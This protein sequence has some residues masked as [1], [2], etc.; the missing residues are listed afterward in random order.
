[1]HRGA[2]AGIRRWR[3]PT[4]WVKVVHLVWVRRAVAASSRRR[5]SS[6][7]RHNCRRALSSA[8]SS[9]SCCCPTRSE[10]RVWLCLR[11][12]PATS[13]KCLSG[14]I[15]FVGAQGK[16]PGRA[17]LCSKTAVASAAGRAGR[18]ERRNL[19]WTD[20]DDE[21]TAK[22]RPAY[23]YQHRLTGAH[24][25]IT[26]RR[27]TEDSACAFLLAETSRSLSTTSAAQLLL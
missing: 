19:V 12:K 9:Q 17:S 2:I 26:P 22:G 24:D 8:V 7:A 5:F 10:V 18:R 3:R 13:G 14:G 25:H 21:W 16:F 20:G 27:L 4:S 6:V 15:P 1:M 11:V 23:Y